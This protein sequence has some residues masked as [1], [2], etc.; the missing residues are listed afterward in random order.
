[1][2]DLIRAKKRALYLLTDMD[3][4]EKELYDKLKKTGYPE[5]VIT[6]TMDYVRGFGYLDDR[7]YA[8]R[9]IG[10]YCDRKSKARLRFDMQKKGLSKEIISEAFEIAGNY[11]ERELIRKLAEKKAKTLDMADPK[12]ISRVA[13]YLSRQ[14]FSS[15]DIMSVIGQDFHCC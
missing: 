13:S 9:Y 10:T 15:S 2:D 5:S 4:T 8:K 12:N 3:R 14:G 7:K 6:E 1:M 11:D